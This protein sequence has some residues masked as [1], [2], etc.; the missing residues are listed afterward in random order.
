MR[1]DRTHLGTK[2]GGTWERIW[3]GPGNECGWG[4]EMNV[5]G[6]GLGARLPLGLLFTSGTFAVLCS[7]WSRYMYTN[8]TKVLLL[9][10]CKVHTWR[11]R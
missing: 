10:N 5:H 9:N 4:Q 11:G 3:V 8:L 1:V 2:V 6:W 7:R